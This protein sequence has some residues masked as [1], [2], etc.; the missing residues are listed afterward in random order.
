MSS[1]PSNRPASAKRSQGL[2]REAARIIAQ[3]QSSDYQ[4]AKRKALKNLGLPAHTPMP[5]NQEIETALFEH[6]RLFGHRV[7]GEHL[8]TLRLSALNAMRDLEVFKP[9]LAGSV[10]R[11]SVDPG[12]VVSL[13]LFAETIEEVG[14]FLQ[15]RGIPF[16]HIERCMTQ[17]PGSKIRIPGF[18][19]VAKE[20]AFEL[21][22]FSGNCRHRV[23]I[24]PIEGKAMHRASVQELEAL[25]ETGTD[26]KFWVG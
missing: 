6:R 11:G 3:G 8:L 13:H 20:V 4:S 22:G 19:L 9:R 25:L 14:F 12:T 1:T 17:G 21:L 10:L 7:D 18:G 15:D 2:A 16:R 24:C 26:E 23:P 5:R